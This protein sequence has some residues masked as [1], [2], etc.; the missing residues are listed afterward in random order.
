MPASVGPTGRGVPVATCRMAQA[1]DPSVEAF[2]GLPQGRPT[3][4]TMQAQRTILPATLLAV[5]ALA[6]P[7]LAHHPMGGTIPA[8]FGQGFLSGL[9]HPVIGLDHLAALVGLGLVAARF[10]RIVLLPALWLVAMVAGTALHQAAIDL[11]LA[12]ALVAAS[13]VVIG[14]AAAIRPTLPS[15]IAALLFI[16]G[17][18]AHGHVL[19]ETIVGA[20]TTPVAAYLL[21][22]V[23]VQGAVAMAVALLARH[24]AGGVVIAPS[25]RLR[26]AGIAVALTGVGALG[27]ATFA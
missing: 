10:S 25:L 11:P 21:G 7:A 12:E 6:T 5:L 19:A 17:G 3:E 27:L 14:L 8:T 23:L 18:L 9:G 26:L 16:I 13:V 1:F 4:T 2:N 20:E 24:V 22:L 15:S